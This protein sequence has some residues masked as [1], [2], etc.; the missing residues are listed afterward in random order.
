MNADPV[1][2]SGVDQTETEVDFLRRQ[3]AENRSMFEQQMRVGD[4]VLGLVYRTTSLALQDQ[5]DELRRL[6]QARS[7]LERRNEKLT[8]SLNNCTSELA[9]IKSELEKIKEINERNFSDAVRL[10][11]E[12]GES[13]AFARALMNELEE[14]KSEY[15][16]E[17]LGVNNEGDDIGGVPGGLKHQLQV[18]QDRV[19][20]IR[21]EAM[22]QFRL[23]WNPDTLK[24]EKMT[25]R[26]QRHA[27]KT[28]TKPA[29]AQVMNVAACG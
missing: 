25:V 2:T 17:V 23:F 13:K 15:D 3:D 22:E 6:R 29:T 11:G 8:L 7:V 9:A 26:Q 10:G 28:W 18:L 24:W 19:C 21:W 5:A 27:K 1:K 14:A 16:R 12:L 20:L 4:R